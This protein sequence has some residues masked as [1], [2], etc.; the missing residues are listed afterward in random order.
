MIEAALQCGVRVI[1]AGESVVVLDNAPDFLWMGEE[2]TRLFQSLFADEAVELDHL[3]SLGL[4]IRFVDRVIIDHQWPFVIHSFEECVPKAFNV[5]GISHQI[6]LMVEVFQGI[7]LA[8]I[9]CKPAF[10]ADNG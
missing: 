4:D 3:E 1:A 8:P 10:G 9:R 7:D 6:R 2:K 5:G